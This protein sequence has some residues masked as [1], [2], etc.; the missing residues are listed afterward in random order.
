MRFAGFWIRFV[1]FFIDGI[2]SG[3]GYVFMVIDPSIA[4]LASL[5]LGVGNQVVLQGLKGQS[6]GKMVVGLQ[7][8]KT[9]GEDI[10]IVTAILRYIGQFIS[11]F[12]LFIGYLMVAFSAKK[13]GLHD[14]IAGTYVIYKKT[15]NQAA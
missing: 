2:V 10:S 8:I 14:K 12:I 9:S 3:L 13:Q 1:A 4:S 7:V 11:A 6:V 5:V 15:R